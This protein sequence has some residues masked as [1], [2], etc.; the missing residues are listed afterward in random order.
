M[1]VSLRTQ[2]LLVAIGLLVGIPLIEAGSEEELPVLVRS[3][4]PVEHPAPPFA[5]GRFEPRTGETIAFVGGTNTFDQQRFGYA[6][7]RIHLAWPDRSLQV[8]NLAWQGD[9]LDR[10]ARPRNFY[11]RT[12]DSQPGSIPDH[13]ERAEPGIIF[14]RFG[15]VESLAG[16]AAFDGYEELVLQLKSLTPRIVLV[17]PTPFFAAGPAAP[18]ADARNERLAEIVD[19][20]RRVAERHELLFVDLFGPLRKEGDEELS[21]NGVHLTEAG[22]RRVAELMASQL[23]FPLPIEG[24]ADTSAMESALSDAIARKNRLWQQY[25]RPTNWAFL[26]GNRQHVPASRDPVERDQRWFVREIDALPALIAESEAD[27]HRYARAAT[28]RLSLPP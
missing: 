8:R 22:H 26:F 28:D 9:V 2:R 13:R 18:L 27:I 12:G 20:I 10:Q 16:P 17:A 11:T 3:F 15:K 21:T 23:D 19:E 4:Q 24:S 14:L 6:E 7:R 25:Y 1:P 5:D